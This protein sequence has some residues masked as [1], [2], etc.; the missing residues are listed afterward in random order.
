MHRMMHGAL[1]GLL[2]AW[3][4]SARVSAQDGAEEKHQHVLRLNAELQ[5][6]VAQLPVA[7]VNT[8][9]DSV[10]FTTLALDDTL[11]VVDGQNNYAFR[12]TTPSTPGDLM[13]AFQLA[14][15]LAEW[16]ICPAS[17]TMTGFKTFSD[18]RLPHDVEGI[19]K[20]GER[21]IIQRH[22]ASYLKPDTEYIMWFHFETGKPAAVRFSLNAVAG[23]ELTVSHLFPVFW[24]GQLAPPGAP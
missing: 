1:A 21:F 23:E 10:K 19:G 16:Y 9:L 3:A 12:F 11:T 20:K 14:P 5:R 2:A 17:G 18:K 24:E 7:T 4:V 6:K 15:G 13:W 8:A 22:Y